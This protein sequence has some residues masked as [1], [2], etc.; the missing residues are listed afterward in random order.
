MTLAAASSSARVP[1]ARHA[2]ATSSSAPRRTACARRGPARARAGADDP[3]GEG[4]YDPFAG[5]R[6]EVE[7]VNMDPLPFPPSV[8]EGMG[9]EEWMGPEDHPLLDKDRNPVSDYI[10]GAAWRA[11]RTRHPRMLQGEKAKRIKEAVFPEDFYGT[12][13]QRALFPEDIDERAYSEYD[14]LP[15]YEG[16]VFNKI[17][18]AHALMAEGKV[19]ERELAYWFRNPDMPEEGFPL[20]IET[21]KVDD[22]EPSDYD[23]R[24]NDNDAFTPFC[25]TLRHLPSAEETLQ[26]GQEL[27][28]VVCGAHVN[29]GVLVDL[30]CDVAGLIPMYH[31]QG[32]IINSRCLEELGDDVFASHFGRDKEVTVRVHALRFQRYSAEGSG[33]GRCVYR[34]PIEVAL[35]S[36]SVSSSLSPPLPPSE[37]DTLAPIRITDPSDPTQWREMCAL[38]G[39][40]LPGVNMKEKGAQGKGKGEGEG[41]GEDEGEGKDEGEGEGEGLDAFVASGYASWVASRREQAQHFNDMDVFD[42]NNDD[43]ESRSSAADPLYGLRGLRDWTE[44]DEL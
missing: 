32:S 30:G 23:L 17:E 8:V 11:M 3:P 20:T 25:P 19:D 39:R 37:G 33:A 14:T 16:P 35:V 1:A 40:S 31:D 38:T 18:N 28:G 36:P 10:G 41:K 21:D 13:Y 15:P 44:D 7:D 5:F 27:R 29:H 4:E 26:V 24:T 2:A 42:P 43:L 9:T 6:G 34:F 12:K 22:Y